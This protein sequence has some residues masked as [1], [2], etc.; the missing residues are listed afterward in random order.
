MRFAPTP[1]IGACL[2]EPDILRDNRGAFART[3]C[4][5]ELAAQ[6]IDFEIV[7]GNLS[8]NTRRGTVRGMH[9]Q[10]APKAEAKLIRCTKGELCDVIVDLRRDSP[11]YCQSFS[12]ELTA[13]NYRILYLP[14]GFAHGFQTLTDDTEV[15][16]EMSEYYSP[17]H[18]AGVR[19]NDPAFDI[20]WPLEITVIS[21]RD[22]AYRNFQP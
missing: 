15:L 2:I 7:Q 1:L 18:A 19:W 10:R 17:E 20:R 9:F 3:F 8:F 22:Q 16:Y 6:G 21:D 14:E 12:V 4:K 5:K 13:K 11:T